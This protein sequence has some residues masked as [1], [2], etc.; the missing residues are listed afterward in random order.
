LTPGAAARRPST[1]SPAATAAKKVSTTTRA[2]PVAS[3]LS[4]VAAKPTASEVVKNL[5]TKVFNSVFCDLH[6]YI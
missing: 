1:V 6:V 3:S 2:T 5:K 4:S